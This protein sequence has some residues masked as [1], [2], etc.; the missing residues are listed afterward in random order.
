[1]RAV[2]EKHE[3]ARFSIPWKAADAGKVDFKGA[4]DMHID[5]SIF[6]ILNA[7][8]EL[9]NV[10]CQWVD[11]TERKKA[12]EA[13]MQSEERLRFLSSRLLEA[14]EAER[15]RIAG[16][17]HDSIGQSLAAIKFNVEN[18]LDK[19]G[20]DLNGRIVNSIEQIVLLVQNSIEE[21]RRIY[22]GLRP[23]MLD[24]LGIIATIGWFCREFQNT[25]ESI[26]I[27]QQLGIEEAEIPEPLKIVIFRIAQEALNNVA[28]HSGAEL[29]NISLESKE[30]R[31]EM[32]IEDNG[33]GFYLDSALLK[34]CHEKGLGIAGM[35]ERAELSGGTFSIESVIGKGTTIHATWPSIAALR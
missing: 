21:V 27:E 1:V 4:R 23:S 32:A 3:P 12:E 22:T 10:V 31:I 6:P 9:T 17:L 5:V 30:G 14:Q 25:Y 20:E 7:Q 35:K 29:V 18:V 24:D 8:G 15:K 16:E 2:F 19:T 11:I 26:C 13:L 34:G 28:R 33:I